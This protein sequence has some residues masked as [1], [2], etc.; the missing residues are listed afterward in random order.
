[1]STR[2]RLAFFTLCDMALT[3]HYDYALPCLARAGWD[4]TVM[5]IG[6]SAGVRVKTM[7]YPCTL[8]DLP[9]LRGRSRLSY[10][11]A[12]RW[13]LMSLRFADFD[14][15]YLHSQ[16]AAVRA[17][18][19]WRIPRWGHKFVYHNADNYCPFLHP[20]H[21]GPEGA[22]SRAADL[23]LCT[24]YHRAYWSRDRFHIRAPIL[25]LPP[26]L[27]LQWPIPPKSAEKRALLAGAAGDQAFVL[28]LHGGYSSVRRVAQLIEALSLVPKSFRLALTSGTGPHPEM[29]ALISKFQLADRIVKLPALSFNEMLSYTVNA[30]AG[31]LLYANS[32][33]GNFFTSPGRLTEYLSCG[34]P[35]L[36]SDH[37]GLENL[38]LRYR[39]GVT[40]DA[41]SPQRIAASM[42]QLRDAL[43]AGQF[44]RA[45]IRRAFEEHLA[46]DHWE[47]RVVE[48]FEE[49]VHGRIRTNEPPEFPWLTA[50]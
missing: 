46:F 38:V 7:P 34:T 17:A 6:A 13:A 33:F 24:E 37:T 25:T 20:R 11:L 10:E 16:A 1:M 41:G 39:L 26:N 30:D 49:L 36:A 9:S 44:Q 29:D 15:I 40:A 19:F 31:V 47:Q 3:P 18:P 27:C 50:P 28:M 8:I 14:V 5:G 23:Y 2:R 32:D 45:Q 12:I 35:V 48:R 42:I 22:T 21:V 4:I 43:L